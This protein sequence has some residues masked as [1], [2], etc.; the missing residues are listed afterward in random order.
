VS[1]RYKVPERRHFYH[2][3]VKLLLDFLEQYLE[4]LRNMLYSSPMEQDEVKNFCTFL[5][6]LFPLRLF[7]GVEHRSCLRKSR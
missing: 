2:L 6:V 7:S 5:N 4:V 3:G 1:Q